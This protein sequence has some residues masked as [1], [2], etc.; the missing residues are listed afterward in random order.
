MFSCSK[1]ISMCRIFT[2][3]LFIILVACDRSV[4]QNQQEYN[5]EKNL[6]RNYRV[7]FEAKYVKAKS[8]LIIRNHPSLD[9]QKIGVIPYGA[10]IEINKKITEPEIVSGKEGQWSEINFNNKTGWV[11]DGYLIDL[12]N[13]PASSIHLYSEMENANLYEFLDK[14]INVD[15]NCWKRLVD[16]KILKKSLHIGAELLLLGRNSLKNDIVKDLTIDELAQGG[17]EL[18]ISGKTGKLNDYLIVDIADYQ[19]YAARLP[20]LKRILVSDQGGQIQKL[21]KIARAKDYKFTNSSSCANIDLSGYICSGVIYLEKFSVIELLDPLNE[22]CSLVSVFENNSIQRSDFGKIIT[23]FSID[24]E[25]Y[26]ALE[27][28]VPQ[29]EATSRSLIK[30]DESGFVVIDKKY[31]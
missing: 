4:E 22:H 16:R 25:D 12:P 29:T 15:A 23:S 17:V 11:F 10:Y 9:G 8:G 26:I 19:R 27:N 3:F 5:N 6:H 24:N 21:C 18:K 28:W 7:V 31:L 14:C 2:F 30:I 20:S 13:F 1:K